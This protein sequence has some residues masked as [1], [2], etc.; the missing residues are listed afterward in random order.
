MLLILPKV[1]SWNKLQL[2]GNLNRSFKNKKN[3][4]ILTKPIN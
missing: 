2:A 1:V 3:V 4:S